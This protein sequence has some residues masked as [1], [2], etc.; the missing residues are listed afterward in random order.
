MNITQNTEHMGVI[1]HVFSITH[2]NPIQF[3][4][5]RA[6]RRSFDEAC[7]LFLFII[8]IIII[9]GARGARKHQ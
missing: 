4:L 2:T 3:M 5:S 8:T 7:K 6:S 1:S 9:I